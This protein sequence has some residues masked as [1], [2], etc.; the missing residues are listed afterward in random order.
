MIGQLVD[1]L[2]ERVRAWWD[3]ADPPER[4]EGTGEVHLDPAYNGRY[5]A[6]RRLKELSDAQDEARPDRSE[7]QSPP[8]MPPEP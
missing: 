1:R 5:T 6:E 8:M 7:T 2:R 4:I 3:L